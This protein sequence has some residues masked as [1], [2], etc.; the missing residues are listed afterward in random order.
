MRIKYFNPIFWEIYFE[1]ARLV[2]NLNVNR[3]FK[4]SINFCLN[5]YI[6][7]PTE[8]CQESKEIFD[9]GKIEF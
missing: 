6:L 9:K 5:N 1:K 4:Y 3:K 2:K 7:F 8:L